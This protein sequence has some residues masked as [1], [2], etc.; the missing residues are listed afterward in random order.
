LFRTYVK[1]FRDDFGV[2]AKSANKNFIKIYHGYEDYARNEA[3]N[4]QPVPRTTPGFFRGGDE[5]VSFYDDTDPAEFYGTIFH[6]GAHQFASAA[7]PGATF[8]P[9]IEE[10]LATYFEGCTYSR[11]TG[12]A[13]LS[14]LPPD[15]LVHAQEQLRAAQA[16]GRVSAQDLFMDLP[17]QSFEAEHYALAWSFVY[18]LIH[19]DGGTKR[20]AF[21]RFLREMNGSGTRP[22]D[23]VFKRATREDL[24]AAERGWPEFVLREKPQPLPEWVVLAVH[25]PDPEVDLRD[26]DELF[27]ID[28]VEVFSEAQLTSLWGKRARDRPIEVVV[29]RR[30]PMPAP[31]GYRR[32][33]VRATVASQSK[34]EVQCKATLSRAFQLSE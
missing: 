20:Q 5:L 14:Y 22:V 11:A 17:Q 13:T 15:R 28:G 16:A 27:S 4:G 25:D 3:E 12:K 30:V 31:V 7:L 24:A 6:E 23:E 29:Y 32:E 19:R 18:Y 2:T 26:G 1:V 33:V 21:A 10:G 8:P 9:W 34:V